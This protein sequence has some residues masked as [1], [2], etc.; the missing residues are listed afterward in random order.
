[1]L[2][3]LINF[4]FPTARNPKEQIK[5]Y[6]PYRYFQKENKICC[7]DD[8]PT[9]DRTVGYIAE[10]Q[11]IVAEVS[12]ITGNIL[13]LYQGYKTEEDLIKQYNGENK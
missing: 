8:Y 4:I 12:R 9:I 13:F 3:K 2:K 11:D 5:L 10:H 1:M 6:S 7:V